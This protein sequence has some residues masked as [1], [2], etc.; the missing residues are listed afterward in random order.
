MEGDTCFKSQACLQPPHFFPGLPLARWLRGA[1][2][3]HTNK[4]DCHWVWLFVGQPSS[5]MSLSR[6]PLAGP[7]FKKI[8]KSGS[9]LEGSKWTQ[10]LTFPHALGPRSLGIFTTSSPSLQTG[11]RGHP[12]PVP[13]PKLWGSERTLFI[14]L[15][16]PPGIHFF[17]S[18]PTPSKKK[19]GKGKPPGLF[20]LSCFS[21]WQLPQPQDR[22]PRAL[23][24]INCFPS[25]PSTSCFISDVITVC[26]SAHRQVRC[27]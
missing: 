7:W 14:Q 21:F 5:L 12:K 9:T 2:T 20:P 1:H 27:N 10:D 18:S 26:F 19:W 23:L 8:L 11:C 4:Q 6:L 22:Q 3:K 15:V 13:T 25:H 17:S 16:Y 24:Y